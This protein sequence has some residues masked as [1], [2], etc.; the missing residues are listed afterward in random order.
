MKS[1]SL[2]RVETGRLLR[3]RLTWL[4]VAVT[5][6]SP[7]IGLILYRPIEGSVT[8]SNLGNPAMAGALVSAIL[9]AF[10]TSLE[11]DRVHRTC[12][13][14]L[15]EAMVTPLSASLCK[16]VALLLAAVL[17]QAIT[18]LVWLP[19]SIVKIGSV[20][21]LWR[22]FAVYLSIMLPA[23][24]IAVLFS[25][26]VY[27]IVRRLDLT[28]V[29]SG[30]FVLVSMVLWSDNWL[31][32]WVN[33]AITYLSDDFSITRIL[34]SVLYNRLF[35]LLLMS[36]LW[37]LSFLCVRRY[38]K[39][40][41]GSLVRNVRKFYLPVVALMLLAAG[42]LT[43]V[44]QPFVDHSKAELNHPEFY[45]IDYN[46][47]VTYSEIRVDARP[48][49]ATGCH[50]GTCTIPLRNESGTEQTISFWLN[51]GY[52]VSHVTA[53][54]VS[55]PF[56][57]LNNDEQ[58]QN[59]IEVDLPAEKALELVI[60]YG[61]FP[62][63]WNILSTGQGAG[64][65]VCRDGMMLL[66][67]AF[68]PLPRDIMGATEM[69]TPFTATISLPADMNLV[70][71]GNATATKIGTNEDGSV[72]WRVDDTG[73]STALYTGDYVSRFIEASGINIEFIYSAKHQRIMDE[74]NVDQV[75]AD[76]FEYC[77]KHYGPLSF[78][79][80]G[81]LKLIETGAGGGYAGNG[82]ST[83][84]EDSFNEEGLRDKKKGARG[85]EV[86]AH[87]I[88]HQWWGMGNMFDLTD[89]SSPWTPEGLTVYSTY[90]M[91]KEQHGGDYARQ[92]YV[93]KWQAEVDDYYQNF[94]VRNP[95]FL[96]ALPEH[97]QIVIRN[98]IE[99]MRKYSEMPL[100]ILKA[101]QLVGGEE[102][103]DEILN[104]LFT[105]ELDPTFPYLTYQNF[106]DACGLAEE[107][108][109]LD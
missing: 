75:L 53:D 92:Y 36:G 42:G 1:F 105:R 17:A 106:L 107:D 84:G 87:E 14:L 12:T 51:P 32:R 66:N 96:E 35:W 55:V 102:K 82:S 20:F 73:W 43:Y 72:N 49:F 104:G 28:L 11:L 89:S 70:V 54:G 19:V 18:L 101:E 23:M 69:P 5:V 86:L 64:E 8:G 71:F 13:D 7:A 41:F 77:T 83:M 94:Y 47:S 38:G 45:N 78:Y 26:C 9:F 67:Q 34:Q 85:S 60:E 16:T 31:L 50:W 88:I 61:G 30:A 79:Q 39:G 90:R 10:L 108:L 95:E 37:C 25:T 100:K 27:Q 48:D 2:L 22:H 6:L 44:G 52:K 4:I 59:T 80:D 91:M 3:L 65:R 99:E 68:S 103:M 15:T 74:C 58:N 98:S 93:D 56:R 21:Q 40:A 76:V 57:D 33:P 63:E 24:V 109:R 81:T 29:L 46:E 62:Q 97:Y